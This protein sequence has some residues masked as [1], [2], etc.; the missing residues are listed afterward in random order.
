MVR[1]GFRE[2]GRF[3]EKTSRGAADAHF[4]VGTP[5]L[6]RTESDLS[7]LGFSIGLV[8]RSP[9]DEDRKLRF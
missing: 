5:S 3:G 2:G 1:G 9:V 8:V 7:G 6:S 4:G